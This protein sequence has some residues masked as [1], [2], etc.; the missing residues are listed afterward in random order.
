[1]A[2]FMNKLMVLGVAAAMAMPGV[3]FAG[4]SPQVNNPNPTGVSIQ[5]IM[6]PP[7]FSQLNGLGSL[8]AGGL[9]NM[10]IK[11]MLTTAITQAVTQLTSQMLG[12]IGGGMLSGI[13][14][15]MVGQS[16][17]G[18]L[19]EQTASIGGIST[20][21]LTSSLGGMQGGLGSLGDSF[22]G[23]LQGAAQDALNGLVQT[24][25][26]Q[27]LGGMQGGGGGS[28]GTSLGGNTNSNSDEQPVL[29]ASAP[30]DTTTINYQAGMLDAARGNG[31]D[32]T[33]VISTYGSTMVWDSN[34]WAGYQKA[35]VAAN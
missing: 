29:S 10:D 14:G 15:G 31:P 25:L 8:A 33:F 2:R 1:M 17:G 32:T 24:G 35:L 3:G 5:N 4:G 20:G 21:G 18:M 19:G 6:S 12:Q 9:G 7:N 22:G 34:Y 16:L 23:L 27:V 26:Q 11:S 13:A 28:G 30:V